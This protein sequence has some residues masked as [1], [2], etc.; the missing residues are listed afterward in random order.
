MRSS[1]EKCLRH[2]RIE[3]IDVVWKFGPY[4]SCRYFC[5]F[6]EVTHEYPTD[7][8]GISWY[9]CLECARLVDTKSWDLL[10]ERGVMACAKLHPKAGDMHVL[11]RQ[12]EQL[13]EDFRI[14]RLANV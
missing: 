7:T 4:S 9:A 3:N 8:E 13:V 2:H 6:P 14:L 1:N 12:L 10:I 11:R 5:A